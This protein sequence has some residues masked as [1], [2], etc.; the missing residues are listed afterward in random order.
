MQFKLHGA[1]QPREGT[2]RRAARQRD[3]MKRILVVDDDPSISYTVSDILREEGYQ[4]EAAPNGR[5]ALRKMRELL[6]DAVLLDLMMPVMDGWAFAR[7]CRQEPTYQ[8]VPIVV[9]SA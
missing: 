7:A 3:S 6:P 4:V 8:D 1:T 5:E 2:G 9:M